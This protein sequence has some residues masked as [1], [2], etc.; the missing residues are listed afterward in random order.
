MSEKSCEYDTANA[1]CAAALCASEPMKASMRTPPTFIAI[2]WMPVG[3]PK[4]NSERI[5]VQSGPKPCPRGKRTTQPPPHSFHSAYTATSPEAITVPIA[6]PVVPKAGMGPS[7]RIRTTLSTRFSSVMA[8][9]RIIGVL[10][11]PAERRAP[12]SMKN[13][14]IPLLYRNVTRRKGSASAF[15]AGAAF[16]RSSSQGE[17]A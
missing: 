10:A 16:T 2:P 11:S 8:T 3:R 14:I 4:R 9:P 13:T 7:P 1:A 5:T 15:T 17:S 6:D 12:P